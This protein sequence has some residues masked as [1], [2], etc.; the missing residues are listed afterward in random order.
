MITPENLKFKGPTRR[1]NQY[2]EVGQPLDWRDGD[3]LN[4]L[5][6]RETNDDLMVLIKAF[7]EDPD[8]G[9]NF[10]HPSIE[11]DNKDTDSD[12]EKNTDGNFPKT[13]C[14]G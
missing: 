13:P 11:G 5:I 14:D 4:L 9:V 10:F 12:K 7:E 3:N 8:M 1:N 2:C 6:S